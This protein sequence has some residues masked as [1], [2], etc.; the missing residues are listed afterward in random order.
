MKEEFLHYLWKYRLYD[1]E[2]LKDDEGNQIIVLHPGEYNRDSG[3]DFFNARIFVK[4]T[5]W[6]GNIEIHVNASHF[7]THGHNLDPVYNNVI[8][9]VVVMN[10]RKVFN[11]RGEEILT[12]VMSY[13][14]DL[15]DRYISLVNNP[16]VIACQ[17]EIGNIDPVFLRQ[18]LSALS[19]ERIEAKTG[20]V[21][22]ILHE[23]GY[24]WEEVFYRML[25]RYFG[26]RV[27]SEPFEMLV[28]S[29]PFRIIRRHSDNILQI[30]ALLFGTAGMLEEGLFRE[31]VNDEY[32]KNLVREFRVLGSKYNIVPMH[33]WLWKFARL[34]PVNFPTVRISQMAHML[35]VTGGLFSRVIETDDPEQLGELMEV[36]A[37]EYWNDHYVFGKKSRHVSRKTGSQA[38]LILVINAVLPVIFVYGRS[39]DRQ[40]ICDRVINFLE[41]MEAEDNLIIREW[42]S[43]GVEAGSAFIS[44]ALIHLRNEYCRK[45]K[46][47]S[48]RIGSRLIYAGRSLDADRETM[49]EP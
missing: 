3:P 4:G 43:A 1:K 19:V 29:L 31:A 6:A 21:M 8:L 49:L 35:S 22:D 13:T 44:Q 11:S 39:R 48:C 28:R 9:H 45:R 26:F 14:E 17:E 40:D 15:Y 32:Y 47:I 10:D 20:P 25:G 37:S 41:K 16:V 33:G 5:I 46:C 42:K 23:T 2:S 34:R 36:P 30:E 12:A 38:T 18:W 7:D 27:N 24:D